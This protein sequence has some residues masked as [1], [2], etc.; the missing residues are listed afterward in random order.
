[1]DPVIGQH[2]AVESLADAFRSRV[3]T[4]VPVDLGP[5]AH[6]AG[7]IDITVSDELPDDT[8]GL[9]V[10][11]A[12]DGFYAVMVNRHDTE[13]RRR[14]TVAHEI[15]HR[16][17]NPD[18]SAHLYRE[19]VAARKGRSAA[20]RECDYFAACL[21][22]PRGLV[23]E[24]SRS[25]HTAGELAHRFQVSLPAMRSRLREIGLNELARS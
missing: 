1:M 4:N 14:F 2:L 13:F 17:L 21:L 5:L 15:G 16:V 10:G 12:L 19:H 3:P 11:S 8:S 18:R 6:L 7:I 20:E 22:M 23:T 25:C 9:L 24:F